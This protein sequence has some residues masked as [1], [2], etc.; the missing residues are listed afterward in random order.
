M[1]VNKLKTMKER[2]R[3]ASVRFSFM[4]VAVVTRVQVLGNWKRISLN[5]FK[6]CNCEVDS[7]ICCA[8]LDFLLDKHRHA[9]R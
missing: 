7:F 1:C 2:S 5:F 3:V 4:Y 8:G 6:F 9:I